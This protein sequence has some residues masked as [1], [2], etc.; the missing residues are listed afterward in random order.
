M[1]ETGPITQ[2]KLLEYFLDAAKPKSE[3]RIG[4]EVE[5]LARHA[6]TG[7]ALLY[8]PGEPSISAILESYKSTRKCSPILEG[9]NLIGLIGSF[10]SITLEPGGQ[11]EW[12]SRPRLIRRHWKFSMELPFH[13]LPS[14]CFV[15]DRNLLAR[16]LEMLD[17]VQRRSGA[18]IILAL[19]GFAMW[20][21]FPQIAKVLQGTTASSV[22]EALLGQETFGGELHVYSVAYTQ[23]ELDVLAGI[24]HHLTF[25]SLSLWERLGKPPTSTCSYGLRI[26]PEYSEV[27]TDL[28][29]PCRPGTRF[30]MTAEQV[31]TADLKGIDGFHFHTMCEQNSDTLARTLNAVE[32]KFGPWLH[33]LKWLNCGGGHHIT[34]DDYDRELLI[35]EIIRMRETYDLEIYL[36]PGEAVALNT[37]YLVSSVVDLFES[38]GQQIAVLDI[39]ATAHMPDVLEMPYRPEIIGAGLPGEKA[40]DYNLGGLSCLAG[41]VIGGYSFDQPLEIGQ[42]LVFT[43]MAH[44]SMV[45]TTMFNGVHH[46]AIAWWDPDTSGLSVVREFGY[47]DYKSRLS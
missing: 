37:G 14:P 43:D 5:R 1:K 20:S 44:Y 2:R 23:H 21:V 15:V 3:W 46:P 27:E 17:D 19:K 4:M 40:H 12:S 38:G 29:N 18:R 7:Q 16:N 39:S 8:G 30:G 6:S 25:N 41:D 42:R 10:G 24:A 11:V 47:T 26:N 28:Y 45:K 33:H 35:R 31:A 36:E 13:E 22:N 34:R 9:A 32:D